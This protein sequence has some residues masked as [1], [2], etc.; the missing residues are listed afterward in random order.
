MGVCDPFARNRQCFSSGKMPLNGTWQHVSLHAMLGG[1]FAYIFL[2]RFSTCLSFK[3][4]S[5]FPDLL[6][7]APLES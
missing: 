7:T 3:V 2:L 5:F 4:Q 1:D 6:D